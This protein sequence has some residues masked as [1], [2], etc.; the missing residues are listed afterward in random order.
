MMW[1]KQYAEVKDQ[2]LEDNSV[3][4]GLIDDKKKKQIWGKI[5][6]PDGSSWEGEW[7]N[8][9]KVGFGKII[10]AEKIQRIGYWAENK[11]GKLCKELRPDGFVFEG[12]L[13]SDKKEGMGVLKDSNGFTY[14][15]EF[16]DDVRHGLGEVCF[17]NGCY[18]VCE[19]ENDLM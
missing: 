16:K 19:W 13:E 12:F 3:Y 7:K 15:G 8:D 14:S 4:S 17:P 11:L 18:L 1:S 9:E 2:H 5:S 10:T 6:Y